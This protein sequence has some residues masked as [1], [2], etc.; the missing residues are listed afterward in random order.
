MEMIPVA[1]TSAKYPGTKSAAACKI[2]FLRFAGSVIKVVRFFVTFFAVKFEPDASI[3]TLRGKNPFACRQRRIMSNVLAVTAFQNGAP[4]ALFVL[5]KVSDSLF[6]WT[7][8][9]S[10]CSQ[11]SSCGARRAATNE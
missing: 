2:K 1:I 6:H 10:V 7:L 8:T 11:C 3:A 4:V 5:F 9:E